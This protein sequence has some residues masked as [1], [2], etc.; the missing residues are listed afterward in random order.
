MSQKSQRALVVESNGK[1]EIITSKVYPSLLPNEVIIKV[2]AVTLNPTDWMHLDGIFGNLER[3]TSL[4]SDFSGDIVEVGAEAQSKGF[5]VGNAVAGFTRGGGIDKDNG[6]FQEYL[7]MPSELIWHKPSALSYEDASCMGGSTLSTAAHSLIYRLGLPKPWGPKPEKFEPILIWGGS[8]SVGL[9]AISLAKLCDN[10]I[11]VIATASPHS[12]ELVKSRGAD[13]VFDYKDPE[14]S[15]KI[16]NW[17]NDKGYPEGIRRGLDCASSNGST[18]L[19]TAAMNGGVLDILLP[20]SPGEGKSWP[21]GV[22]VR[23]VN[24]YYVLDPKN[25]KDHADMHE[26]YQRLPSLIT[27]KNFVNSNVLEVSNGLESIPAGIDRLRS[28]KVSGKKL[29]II[30]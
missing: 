17:V 14:V 8:S 5:A 21:N 1:T 11:P 10:R 18:A 3:G 15:Q 13:V 22:D 4:G 16:R 2:K 19:A 28:G 7:K 20:V 27:E 23:N 30:L 24:I 6:T 26:W 12:F 29:A 9:Y 25:T